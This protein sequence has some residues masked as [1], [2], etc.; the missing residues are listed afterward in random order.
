[1]AAN[2]SNLGPAGNG[3]FLRIL[4]LVYLIKMIRQRRRAR[5]GGHEKITIASRAGAKR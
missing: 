4:G 3:G 2:Q 1:M 5:R